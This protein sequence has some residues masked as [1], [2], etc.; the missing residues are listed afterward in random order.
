[1]NFCVLEPV[2]FFWQKYTLK[3]SKHFKY[4]EILRWCDFFLISLSNM[5][6]FI[7]KLS[8]F[9]GKKFRVHLNEIYSKHSHE[10]SQH[11]QLSCYHPVFS[12]GAWLYYCIC[13]K[14]MIRS[15]PVNTEEVWADTNEKLNEQWRTQ[16]TYI[17]IGHC[18][19]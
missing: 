2:L 7:L 10:I 17:C 13:V 8:K 16:K 4:C 19:C 11:F 6:S 18:F 15:E 3:L 12:Y 9:R 1:M 14:I 5:E